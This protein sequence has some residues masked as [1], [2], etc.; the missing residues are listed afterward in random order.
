MEH[1]GHVIMSSLRNKLFS[2]P[3]RYNILSTSLR[4]SE[5][6]RVLVYPVT[7]AWPLLVQS[8][9][10]W[11][12]L[13]PSASPILISGQERKCLNSLPA[14]STCT[15]GARRLG[16]HPTGVHWPAVAGDTGLMEICRGTGP[17]VQIFSHEIMIY[18]HGLN[19]G[20]PVYLIYCILSTW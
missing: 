19:G 14:S 1:C 16:S 13:A 6:E 12:A 5:L 17:P 9:C 4:H 11:R 7:P 8:V 18:T 10:W 20:P 15:S 3:G 2:T